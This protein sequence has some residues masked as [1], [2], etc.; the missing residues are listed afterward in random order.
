VLQFLL[1]LESRV[2]EQY[3]REEEAG[4]G[5]EC[6]RGQQECSVPEPDEPAENAQRDEPESFIGKN[7]LGAPARRIASQIKPMLDLCSNDTLSR[8][9][10]FVSVSEAPNSR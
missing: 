6:G 10:S 7:T 9:T 1:P 2:I 5:T 8:L 4:Y 3:V